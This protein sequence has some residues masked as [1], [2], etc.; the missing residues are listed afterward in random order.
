[1]FEEDVLDT[2][3]ASPSEGG[4]FEMGCGCCGACECWLEGTCKRTC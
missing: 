4:D 3:E 1:V 2:P